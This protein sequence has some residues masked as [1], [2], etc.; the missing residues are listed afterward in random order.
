MYGNFPSKSLAVYDI[1]SN[2]FL[3]LNQLLRKQ[4]TFIGDS[5]MKTD[6]RIDQA[7]K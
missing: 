3:N 5:G 4:L 6:V 2:I 1:S 7:L